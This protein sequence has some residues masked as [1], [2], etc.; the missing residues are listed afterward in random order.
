MKGDLDKPCRDRTELSSD[1]FRAGNFPCKTLLFRIINRLIF[2]IVLAAISIGIHVVRES[3]GN[4]KLAR[5]PFI[6]AGH[7]VSAQFNGIDMSDF[8]EIDLDPAIPAIAD[9][10]RPGTIQTV[11]Q[12]GGPVNAGRKSIL[13]HCRA[14]LPIS[15]ERQILFP[16]ELACQAERWLIAGLANDPFFAGIGCDDA[17]GFN[18]PLLAPEEVDKRVMIFIKERAHIGRKDKT[19]DHK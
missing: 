14:G 7:P 8:T 5:V 17:A 3:H 13:C 6:E 9:P 19:G 11:I 15:L 18:G 10:A 2:N 4:D 12:I 16:V 1:C